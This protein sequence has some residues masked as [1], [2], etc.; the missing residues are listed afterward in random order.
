MEKQTL[1]TFVLNATNMIT[2]PA[3]NFIGVDAGSASTLE[4]S[5]FE[6]DG[7]ASPVRVIC[8]V[9]VTKGSL[10]QACETLAGALAG[11]S[12]SLTVVSDD[13]NA[14]HL[15]PFTGVNSIS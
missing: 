10:K 9:D 13:V 3:K 11:Q 15:F 8:E 12:R 14:K 2:L 1:L 5:F 6:E 7:T 4:I